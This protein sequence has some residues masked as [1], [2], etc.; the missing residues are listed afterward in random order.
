MDGSMMQAMN[1]RPSRTTAEPGRRQY[2][3]SRRA[4]QAAQTRQDV[5]AAAIKL[6]TTSGWS[7]TTVTGVATEAGVAVETIYSGFRAKKGLLR[8]AMDMAVVGD[9]EPVPFVERP[10]F[11]RLG[12]GPLGKRLAAGISVLADIH[13]RSAGVWRAFLEAAAS[14][15]EI[16]GWRVELERARK[17]D[18]GRSLAVIWDRDLDEPTLDLLW[19]LLGPEVYLRLTADAGWSR[20][21]Y[22]SH[23][24]HAV[25]RLVPPSAKAKRASRR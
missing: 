7:G 20:A 1:S 11:Q 5:L 13:Q 8:A 16:D 4:L 22:E 15:R 10:E 19:A 14:D 17:V 24:L 2:N 9:A 21:D 18:L 12:V 3:S 25:E 6:F 23:M